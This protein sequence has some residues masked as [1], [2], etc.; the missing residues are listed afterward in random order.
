MPY[1]VFQAC[2][3]SLCSTIWNVG[4]EICLWCTW[5]SLRKLSFLLASVRVKQPRWA[6]CERS[7]LGLS[8]GLGS[9]LFSAWWGGEGQREGLL[10]ILG[11]FCAP[12]ADDG[13]FSSFSPRVGWKCVYGSGGSWKLEGWEGGGDGDQQVV[14]QERPEQPFSVLHLAKITENRWW[15]V[16]APW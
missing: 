9:R 11:V 1:T 7:W 3:D 8:P 4:S 2:A 12:C 15:P 16:L 5:R 6:A 13:W 14:K 10:L